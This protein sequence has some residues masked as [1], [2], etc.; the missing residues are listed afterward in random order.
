[1]LIK[2]SNET[3]YYKN[4]GH[5]SENIKAPT[6]NLADN[7]YVFKNVMLNTRDSGRADYHLIFRRLKKVADWN[8]QPYLIGIN[9]RNSG[10]LYM[11]KNLYN[12]S[13]NLRSLKSMLY[14]RISI[15]QN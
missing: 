2:A 14:V 8:H 12:K 1:M 15:F 3:I 11:A 13:K 7:E 10:M 9:I 6:A 4:N 5:P